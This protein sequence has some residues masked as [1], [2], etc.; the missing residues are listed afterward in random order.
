MTRKSHTVRD[1]P[2]APDIRCARCGSII[3]D[4]PGRPV[5]YYSQE[6]RAAIFFC[7]RCT[8][9]ELRSDALPGRPA[10]A[11]ELAAIKMEALAAQ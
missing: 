6:D 3:V 1:M 5:R 4:T 9:T 10:T 8:G 11:G 2:V 7:G